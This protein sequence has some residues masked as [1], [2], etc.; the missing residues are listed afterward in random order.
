M[1]NN[2]N[3]KNT[4]PLSPHLMIYKP[5]ITSILSISHRITG[6]GLFLGTIILAWW[7]FFNV[8]GCT[9]C[10]NPLIFSVVG[11][12]FLVLWTLA[13][14]YH[15]LN[16]IRHLFWDTGKGFELKTLRKSGIFVVLGAVVLTLASWLYVLNI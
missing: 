1:P 3:Q 10:I 5:Q 11:R 7:V 8:Y 12:F 2:K 9:S 6:L 4:R 16:G 14:Y 15:M 13:L